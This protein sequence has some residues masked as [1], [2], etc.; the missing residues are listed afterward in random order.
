MVHSAQ[1]WA[2]GLPSR[3]PQVKAKKKDNSLLDSVKCQKQNVKE[4]K[5]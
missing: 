1:D 3:G 2:A 4:R 5:I